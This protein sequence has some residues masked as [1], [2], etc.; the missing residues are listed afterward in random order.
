[1][2]SKQKNEQGSRKPKIALRAFKCVI[3]IPAIGIFLQRHHTLEKLMGK[4]QGCEK[5]GRCDELMNSH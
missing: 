1:M 4:P 3:C 5:L 2:L